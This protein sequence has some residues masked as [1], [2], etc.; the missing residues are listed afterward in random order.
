MSNYQLE[1]MRQRVRDLMGRRDYLLGV[2]EAEG[3]NAATGLHRAV[4][5]VE[6]Q[7]AVARGEL[8]EASGLPPLVC[9]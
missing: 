1:A 6:S 5:T 2:L 3:A 7:I 9:S 4:A 8:R